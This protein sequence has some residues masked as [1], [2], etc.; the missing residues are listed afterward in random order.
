MNG[1]SLCGGCVKIQL[2]SGNGRCN[3]T[4][5]INIFNIRNWHHV[6]CHYIPYFRLWIIIFAFGICSEELSR[7]GDGPQESFHNSR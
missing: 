5:S 6:T 1:D 2:D 7:M 4:E 3:V